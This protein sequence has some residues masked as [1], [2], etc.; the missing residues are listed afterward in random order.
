MAEIVIRC[1]RSVDYEP[2]IQ[3]LAGNGYPVDQ[4]TRWWFERLLGQPSNCAWYTAQMDGQIV[5]SIFGEKLST[6]YSIIEELAVGRGLAAAAEIA[7]SL[8]AAAM[9]ALSRCGCRAITCYQGDEPPREISLAANQSGGQ[10]MVT[11]SIRKATEDDFTAIHQLISQQ[12]L[13]STGFGLDRFRQM[14]A[15]PHACFV[16]ERVTGT[17]GEH[18][19]P[20]IAGTIFGHLVGGTDGYLGKL[21]VD[22][23]RHG[24][25]GLGA[26]LVRQAAAEL[27]SHGAQRIFAVVRPENRLAQRCFTSAGFNT[28]AEY[29]LWHTI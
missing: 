3:L 24:G 17:E 11:Y 15:E 26:W 20:E 13:L 10:I 14:L 4:L 16:A 2:V 5:G 23:V 22:S 29:D 27:R 19:E 28:G 25:H 7:E 6:H 21:A 1:L 9:V 12:G 8:I 18:P